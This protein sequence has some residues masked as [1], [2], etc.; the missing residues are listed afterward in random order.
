MDGRSPSFEY[1][2]NKQQATEATSENCRIF[3]GLEKITQQTDKQT[4]KQAQL[5]ETVFSLESIFVSENSHSFIVWR[6]L[7]FAK[8]PQTGNEWARYEHV[9]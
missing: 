8:E 2:A 5:T 9:P 7:K 3:L 1:C 4:N 6:S